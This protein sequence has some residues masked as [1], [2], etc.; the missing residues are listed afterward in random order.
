M[1]AAEEQLRVRAQSRAGR[2]G[3]VFLSKLLPPN[4]NGNRVNRAETGYR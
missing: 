2:G 1:H 4:P 3:K